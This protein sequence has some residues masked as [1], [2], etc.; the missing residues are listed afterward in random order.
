[1]CRGTNFKKVVRYNGIDD[2]PIDEDINPPFVYEGYE[3]IEE[4]TQPNKIQTTRK[5]IVIP[6]VVKVKTG[7]P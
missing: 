1:M 2:S 6:E 4:P 5:N 7:R 3:E